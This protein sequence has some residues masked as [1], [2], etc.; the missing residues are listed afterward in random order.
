[1][2]VETR[3]HIIAPGREPRLRSPAPL[4]LRVHRRGEPAREALAA[5]LPAA[6]DRPASRIV[7]GCELGHR[8][9]AVVGLRAGA[10]G[11][12]SVE[13]HFRRA[14]ER[15]LE[16]ALC[17]PVERRHVVEFDGLHLLRPRHAERVFTE[18][19]AFLHGAGFQWVLAAVSPKQFRRLERL[20]FDPVDLLICPR[21]DGGSE[22]IVCCGSVTAAYRLL[23]KRFARDPDAV[24]RWNHT[25]AAGRRFRIDRAMRLLETVGI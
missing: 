5:L 7:V 9:A 16:R 1:M 13:A 15:E 18:F 11:R 2:Q 17:V 23:T 25:A 8:L 14:A 12:F 24:E 19:A 6:A 21:L 4:R 20:A 10:D 3:E 22:T